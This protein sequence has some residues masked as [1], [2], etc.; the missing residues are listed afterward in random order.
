MK[1][2]LS[3][4]QT[5]NILTLGCSKN[6]VDSEVLLRQLQ[7]AGFKI[8][9]D[10]DKQ[11]DV[12]IVNTCGFIH[13][14]KEESVNTILQYTQARKNGDLQKLI[15]MGC[16]SERY[17]EELI[18]EIPEVDAFF[19]VNDV[20][21]ILQS[22]NSEFKDALLGERVITTLPHYAYLKISE[23]CDRTCSFCAIPGIRGKNISRSVESLVKEA[24]FLVDQGVKE[25]ML[26]AQDLTYYGID[27]Y[28]KRMLP[29]LLE[30]LVKINGLEWIRLHYAYP[31][32]FPVELLDVMAR[33]DKICKYIDIPLQHVNSRILKSMRRNIDRE[34]TR[35]LV[36]TIREKVPGITIRSSFIVGY[37][38]ETAAE[39]A[40]LRDFIAESSFERVGVFTYSHEENTPAW[41]LQDNVRPAI[42]ARRAEEIMLLQQDISA[43][44]NNSF[45]GRKVKIMVD[46]Q[47]GDYWIGR[48]E[49]DSPEVDN[50]VIVKNY[51]GKLVPGDFTEVLI[52]SADMYD[53]IADYSAE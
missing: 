41:Q 26:I 36:K 24:S 42:K 39:F 17:K 21:A 38:G 6:L 48:T 16:L 15:V 5:V 28:G 46:K 8:L 13:D 9:H 50:E 20:N 52:T 30:E 22:L 45:V 10:S 19:G 37:P 49:F 1:T 40:E 4:N 43:S 12:V 44:H 7:A 18:R 34:G 27:L 35:K 53:L 11:A 2:R 29:D 23:G 51:P 32:G 25:L 33:H 14:A 47:E 3:K 31:A